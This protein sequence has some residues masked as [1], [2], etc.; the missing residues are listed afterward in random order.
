MFKLT[1]QAFIL[2]GILLG[3]IL[4]QMLSRKVLKWAGFAGLGL[5]LISATYTPVALGQWLND[6]E[7]SGLDGKAFLESWYPGDAEA[8]AWLDEHIEGQPVML[9][10][11]GKSYERTGRISAMTGIPCLLGWHTHEHLWRGDIDAVNRIS[12]EILSAYGSKDADNIRKFLDKYQIELIYIGDEER[13]AVPDID[14]D[15]FKSLGTVLYEDS[16]AVVI[17]YKPD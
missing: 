12:S 6:Q 15:L 9:E 3:Y 16:A 13:E 11:D 17:Q 7:Y 8:I 4:I 1:Y 2:F 5:V 10:I 14:E